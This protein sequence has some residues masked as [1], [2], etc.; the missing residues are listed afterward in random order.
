MD[1]SDSRCA[2]ANFTFGLYDTPCPDKGRADGSPVFRVDLSTHA[3]AHTPREPSARFGSS[4]DDV[5][6]AVT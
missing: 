2:A 6:F 4:A 1:P 3:A 5:A